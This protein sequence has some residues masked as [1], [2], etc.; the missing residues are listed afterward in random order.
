M[1]LDADA[2]LGDAPHIDVPTQEDIESLLLK[3]RKQLLLEQYASAE[4][5]ENTDNA[6]AMAGTAQLL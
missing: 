1:E 4:M 5:R 6:K 3:R 2:P